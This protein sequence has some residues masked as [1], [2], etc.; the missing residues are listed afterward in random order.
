MLKKVE[1][2]IRDIENQPLS[3]S[4]P[5]ALTIAL[6]CKDYQ[7]Y[8]VLS[9]F[10]F[11]VREN[12]KANIIQKKELCNVLAVHG[13]S[14]EKIIEI[15]NKSAEEYL[16]IKTIDKN[17]VSSHSIKEIELWF[18]ESKEFLKE[19]NSL[20]TDI[21]TM[22]SEKTRQMRR[23][24]EAIKAYVASKLTFYHEVLKSTN[25]NL[26]KQGSEK[27]QPEVFDMTKVFIV[28][29]HN[30][31]IKEAVARLIEN[32]GIQAII[33]HEKANQGSTIIEKFERNSD[34]GCAVCLFT[35]DDLGHAKTDS[36]EKTRARQNVVFE[37]GYFIGKLGR[38]KVI[39]IA[40][41]DIEMPSDLQGVV[42][43]NSQDWRF[44]VLRE[45]KA[46]GY[47]IDYNKLD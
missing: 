43:T 29:G 11:P 13:L 47:N 38:D 37:T 45:L 3:K 36:K 19:P 20:T 25:R 26:L 34:V 44:S 42:Y 24:Y 30:G 23:M 15:V 10:C 21:Y 17:Q 5:L 33:L 41:K 6:E 18:D 31:E 2:L 8:C 32:Q 7:G 39:L 22:A 27:K 14:N 46:I 12:S 28:H 4:I 16:E 9:Y 35:A 40:D 1:D